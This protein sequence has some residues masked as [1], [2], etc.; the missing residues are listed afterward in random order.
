MFNVAGTSCSDMLQRQNSCI[1]HTEATYSREV[2]RGHVAE[3]KSQYVHTHED[4]A[5]ACFRGV[6]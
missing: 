3:T 6:L 1:V 5:G 4:V 2:S